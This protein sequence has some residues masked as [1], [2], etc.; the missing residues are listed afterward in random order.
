MVA[1]IVG[2]SNY[3]GYLRTHPSLGGLRNNEVL[4]LCVS[5]HYS[6]RELEVGLGRNGDCPNDDNGRLDFR[7]GYTLI[8]PVMPSVFI[9]RQ[10]VI[11]PCTNVLSQRR[12]LADKSQQKSQ[13]SI[14]KRLVTF[15][16]PVY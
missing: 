3:G 11:R 14:V 16:E 9:S 10:R 4:R 5:K 6:L 2:V 12:T 1:V 15:L 8:V 7:L 13:C